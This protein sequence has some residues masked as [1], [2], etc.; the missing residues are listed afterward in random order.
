VSTKAA[1][2]AYP[3]ASPSEL[4]LPRLLTAREVA[5]VLNVSLSHVYEQTALGHIPCVRVG[6]LIRY[7][8]EA[9][10]EASPMEATS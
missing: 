7:D 4:G 10:L 6:R 2:K 3:T 9:I 1:K 5:G 8:P